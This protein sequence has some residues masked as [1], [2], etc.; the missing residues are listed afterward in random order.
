MNYVF[1]FAVF[2]ALLAVRLLPL[3]LIVWLFVTIL[4]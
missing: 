3:F 2:L 1:G 4:S